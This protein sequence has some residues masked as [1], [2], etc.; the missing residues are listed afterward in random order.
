M[1]TIEE[2]I[3]LFEEVGLTT[4]ANELKCKKEIERLSSLRFKPITGDR[5]RE[6]LCSKPYIS[7]SEQWEIVSEFHFAWH[8]HCNPGTC[9]NWVKVEKQEEKLPVLDSCELAN[10]KHAIPYGG[11]LAV[12]EAKEAGLTDFH[13]YFPSTEKGFLKRHDPVIVGYVGR[14]SHK[15]TWGSSKDCGVLHRREVGMHTHQYIDH[16][17]IMCEVFSWDDGQVF[18]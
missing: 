4:Q 16:F 6:M 7:K 12:K 14:I 2:K 15:V 3:A 5:I 10:W 18:E 11:A 17:G 9:S 8:L 1:P 13:I